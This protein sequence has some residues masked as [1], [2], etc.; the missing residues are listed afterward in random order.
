MTKTDSTTQLTTDPYTHGVLHTT[1]SKVQDKLNQN[2]N[3]AYTTATDSVTKAAE[4]TYFVL[5]T[6]MT[7][8]ER[9]AGHEPWDNQPHIDDMVSWLEHQI[10]YGK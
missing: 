7:M 2:H 6:V 10:V 3:L 4:E 9:T 8:L 1:L 5:G